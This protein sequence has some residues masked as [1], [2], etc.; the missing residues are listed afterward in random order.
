MDKD[1]YNTSIPLKKRKIMDTTTKIECECSNNSHSMAKKPKIDPETFN[2][3]SKY[4]EETYA[5]AAQR[6][7]A[8]CK[9]MYELAR[10]LEKILEEIKPHVKELLLL[11]DF[12]EPQP[13]LDH[14]KSCK[15]FNLGNCPT[16][17][18]LHH[19]DRNKQKI[20]SHFCMICKS[21]LGV[22]LEHPSIT[23]K[24]LTQVDAIT[25]SPRVKDTISMKDHDYYLNT[26]PTSSTG[27][28]DTEP[29]STTGSPHSDISSNNMDT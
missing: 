2:V 1:N 22:G 26:E 11:Y 9:N 21:A 5:S 6:R 13:P 28:P 24:L 29:T 15:Y 12:E 18:I 27:S 25:T 3:Q 16:K 14:L 20:T 8:N 4:P 17:K 7:L 19:E 23:C 10:T